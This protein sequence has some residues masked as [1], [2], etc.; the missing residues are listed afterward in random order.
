[1]KNA[2]LLLDTSTWCTFAMFTSLAI[3]RAPTSSFHS[4]TTKSN[5]IQSKFLISIRAASW[6]I[7]AKFQLQEFLYCFALIICVLP[8]KSSCKWTIK[9]KDARLSITTALSKAHTCLGELYKWIFNQPRW[10]AMAMM[11]KG[12]VMR[13]M[14]TQD[15][16]VPSWLKLE[17]DVHWAWR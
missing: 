9:K 2:Q 17:R 3:T 4:N 6:W 14:K 8:N 7:N 10:T 13:A 11:L 15:M 16:V 5:S 12:F 1:M